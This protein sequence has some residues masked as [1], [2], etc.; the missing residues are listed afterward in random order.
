MVGSKT[1]ETVIVVHG[2][3]MKG[4]FAAGV[5]YGLSKVGIKTTDIL[6][7]M[8]SSVPTVAY[9]AS[10]QFEFIKDIWLKEVGSREFV[11]YFNLFRGRP[12]FNLPYL[13]DIV[14][15]QKHPLAV[16]SILGSESL[17]LMPLYNYLESR[18]ELFSNHQE[19]TRVHFW[20]ILQAA[21]TVHNEHI[22]R[23]T[24]FEQ[25]VDSD[26]DPF[27]FYRQE[28]IPAN[29][30]VLLIINHKDLDDTLKRWMGV[31]IF[32][33]LQSR[34]FPK[35]V[36]E[37]LKIRAK[38]IESGLKSFEEFKIKYRPVIISP[39]SSTE[40]T[41]DT[42]ITRDKKKLKTLFNSGVRAVTDM[43]INNE[44]KQELEVFIARSIRLSKTVL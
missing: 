32:R 19:Q 5:M 9:F 14:F 8:S 4:V 24:G 13:I 40:L 21:I 36:N 10:K 15:K 20:K 12:I 38:L 11:N 34:H 31:R 6:I 16:E 27:A 17:F 29:H 7:G 28:I 30:N 35:G 42:L 44:T 22:I 37:K 1:D 26:L 41:V 2:G 33:I 43:I 25:Y 18:L 23:E 3:A 39:L